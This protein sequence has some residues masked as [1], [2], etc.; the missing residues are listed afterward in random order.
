METTTS[1]ELEVAVET[2]V[3]F[4]STLFDEKDVVLFRPIETWVENGK[5]RSRVDYTNNEYRSADPEVLRSLIR[6]LL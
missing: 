3:R 2:A 4:L 1:P 6:R 5:K